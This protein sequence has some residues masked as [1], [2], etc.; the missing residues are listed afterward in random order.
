[1]IKL[2]HFAD[3]H[4]GMENYGRLDPQ[5]GLSTRVVDFLRAFDH[6]IDFAAEE[7]VDLVVFAGDAFRTRD[8]SP[9]YQREFARRIHRLAHGLRIPVFLLVGNHD[10]PNAVGHAHAI[11]IFDTLEVE[12][13]RVARR[14]DIYCIET[15]HGPIQIVALPWV[16]RSALLTR[17]E[18]KNLNLDEIHQL[19]LNKLEG[20]ILGEQG[21]A[22]RLDAEIPAIMV[23]HGTVQGAVYGSERS[24]ML[25]RDLVLPPSLI[26]H[27][28]FDYV[29][30]GHIHRHQ[31]L[32]DDPPAVYAGSLERIDFGEA[33]E[34]KGFVVVELEKGRAA[35]R[36]VPVNARRFVSIRVRA[37][38]EDPTRQVL[39][40]IERHSIADAVVRLTIETTVEAESR[41]DDAAIR[42]ALAPAFYIAAISREIE[43]PTRLRLGSQESI[44]ALTP[45]QILERY[46]IAK[47]V[48]P[49]RIDRLLRYAREIIDPSGE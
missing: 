42:R 6:L 48:P 11:E 38:G 12:N 24:V 10:L 29:A 35:W 19:M 25:G 40:A 4:L 16:T 5:T 7:S 31:C 18:Y 37:D 3:L 36:F 34:R 8:P 2:I 49:E 9:T 20:V 13:V 47:Q 15:R 23:A 33:S 41:L 14:S 30:L 26:R 45:I 39:E 1:M 43:R 27:P 28:A 22:N 44:E 21:L 46:L 32:F 17:D